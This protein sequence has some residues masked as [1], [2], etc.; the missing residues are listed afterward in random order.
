MSKAFVRDD[1]P[2]VDPLD[3]VDDEALLPAPGVPRYITPAGRAALE[4]ELV[5][6]AEDERPR[7]A[8]T[9]AASTESPES[10]EHVLAK[11]RLRDI[12]RRVRFLSKLLERLTVVEPSPAQEGRVFFG[13][14]V[15]TADEEGHEATYRIVGPDE[16]DPDAGRISVESPLA[17]AMLGKAEGDRAVVRRPKGAIELTIEAIRYER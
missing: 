11:R 7:A 2:G 16:A 14:T 8:S 1:D 15:T 4:R 6:L 13:A 5:A 9:V 3:E 17:K 10:A 12:D